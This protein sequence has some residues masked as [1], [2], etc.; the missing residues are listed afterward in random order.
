M[1]EAVEFIEV[2][3]KSGRPNPTPEERLIGTYPVEADAVAAGRAAKASF[4]SAGRTEYDGG[5]YA[6]KVRSWPIGSLT[7]PTIRSSYWIFG[8]ANW[9]RSNN[10]LFPQPMSCVCRHDRV[11]SLGPMRGRQ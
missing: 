6:T 7:P 11:R 9:S 3:E 1:F 8:P 5:W 4:H 10:S 2:E